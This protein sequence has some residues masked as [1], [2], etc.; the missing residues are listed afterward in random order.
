MAIC[1]RLFLVTLSVTG[2]LAC[3]AAT[4]GEL[5]VPEQYDTIQS[6]INKA[7]SGDTVLVAAGRYRER[8]HLRPRVTVRTAGDSTPGKRGLLRAEQ[9]VLDG[10]GVAGISLP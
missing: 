7:A 9:T 1:I 8:I 5:R 6:A 2:V 4:G 10:G 3:H